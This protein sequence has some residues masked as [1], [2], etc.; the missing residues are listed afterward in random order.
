MSKALG[1]CAFV[2]A[3]SM[4]LTCTA[5]PSNAAVQTASGATDASASKIA[6]L[7]VA[8]MPDLGAG[9]TQYRK[10]GGVGK[11]GKNDCTIKAG[12]SI[13]ASDTGYAGPMYTDATKSMFAYSNAIVFK[14]EANAKAYT[15]AKATRAF[16]NCQVAQD[17]VAQQKQNPNT[18]VR[19]YQTSTSDV[20]GPDG[21]E[22]YYSETAGTKNTDGTDALSAQYLRFTY[23]HGRVVYTLK[24]DSGLA[25]D[26][27]GRAAQGE[28]IGNTVQGM[29]T[30]I[31]ARLTAAGT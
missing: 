20:G 29:N 30:A 15:A 3:C 18:F 13:K 19:L 16:Q 4:L 6:K 10:A 25:A 28:Q 27:A 5:A 31:E 21:L 7:A 26:D 8:T 9:W 17:N 1:F 14:T 2:V 24:L 11:F 12:S 23:R 22:A